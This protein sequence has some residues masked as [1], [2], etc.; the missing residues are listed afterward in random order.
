MLE[1]RSLSFY[2]KG[3]PIHYLRF[4][5]G[6]PCLIALHGYGDSASLYHPLASTLSKNYTVY[7]IDLPYH[8]QTRWQS[9]R[10]YT[11]A[12]V[13]GMVGELCRI[14]GIYRFSLLGYSMG[15]RLA[16]RLV[17]PFAHRLDSL[18]LI[19]P[20]GIR[21]HPLLRYAEL[22]QWVIRGLAF[23]IKQPDGV[24]RLMR[25]A[26]YMGLLSRTVY[27]FNKKLL[28]THT[29]RERLYYTWLS[30]RQFRL[31]VPLIKRLLR[32]ER[33][34]VHLFWGKHD[35]IVRPYTARFFVRDLPL[36]QL[37]WVEGGHFVVNEKLNAAFQNAILHDKPADHER[38][39]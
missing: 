29:R 3:T 17:E 8:G 32:R 15:G 21:I 20:S 2:Y 37:H 1:V 39:P 30:V 14:E 16:L 5:N 36:C 6:K 31:N 38:L 28:K 25:W 27:H 13:Q 33:V 12:D 24:F 23:A 10:P 11:P 22:P 9:D 19:A 26:R 35:E 34:Q 18:W 7:S 4:G